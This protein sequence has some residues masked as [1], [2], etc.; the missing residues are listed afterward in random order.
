MKSNQSE[1]WLSSTKLVGVTK[2]YPNEMEPIPNTAW[3]AKK[4]RLDS[5]KIQGKTKYYG[6]A[7]GS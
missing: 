2:Q 4:L 7:K 1:L 3:M 6:S 5:P